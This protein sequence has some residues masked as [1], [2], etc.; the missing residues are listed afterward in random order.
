MTWLRRS[1]ALRPACLPSAC[2]GL[3]TPRSGA[4]DL[5]SGLGVCYRLL[6]RLP[7]QDFHLR[8]ER[9]FVRTHR[10]ASVQRVESFA[11]ATRGGFLPTPETTCTP[12]SLSLSA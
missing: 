9:V 8:E 10:Q 11:I 6:Q 3:S 4:S 2:S 5:S 7:G 12:S 1:L